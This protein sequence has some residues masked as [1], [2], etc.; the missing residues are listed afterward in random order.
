MK[1]KDLITRYGE[2]GH[3]YDIA[4]GPLMR[5]RSELPVARAATGRTLPALT[6]MEIQ[7]ILDEE[8]AT[9]GRSD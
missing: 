2:Q 9:G 5:Q 3:R 6:N 1:S 8:D 7:S 4:H